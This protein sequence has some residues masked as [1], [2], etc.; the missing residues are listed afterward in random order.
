M[1]KLE[2]GPPPTTHEARFGAAQ[3]TLQNQ[4]GAGGD[5]ER[6]CRHMEVPSPFRRPVLPSL[7]NDPPPPPRTH[8]S[9]DAEVPSTAGAPIAL[10][11]RQEA[12]RQ[13]CPSNRSNSQERFMRASG[14]SGSLL[15]RSF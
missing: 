1:A 8:L 6:I 15:R 10:P 14:E 3:R 9:S 13:P 4:R 11:R 5:N 2:C 12:V 7:L